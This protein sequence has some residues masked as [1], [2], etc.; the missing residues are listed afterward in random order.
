MKFTLPEFGARTFDF[1]KP[2]SLRQAGL[3][4]VPSSGAIIVKMMNLTRD[5]Q[6][7]GKKQ[8]VMVNEHD[9]S[10]PI[11]YF[12]ADPWMELG[13]ICVSLNRTLVLRGRWTF[14]KE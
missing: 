14:M 5:E 6:I 12:D 2:P 9:L 10:I 7:D 8:R 1:S 11:E 4:E 3:V 13:N